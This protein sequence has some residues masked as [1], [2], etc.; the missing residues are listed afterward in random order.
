MEPHGRRVTILTHRLP[1]PVKKKHI[2]LDHYQL[3]FTSEFS[4]E[5][6]GFFS[7]C[8]MDLLCNEDTRLATHVRSKQNRTPRYTKYQ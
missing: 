1:S 6:K 3:L 7:F 8:L 2:Q 4:Y 5:R